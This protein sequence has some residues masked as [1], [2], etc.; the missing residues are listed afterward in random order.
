MQEIL[1]PQNPEQVRDAILWAA[2]S[3]T[4]LE[5][6]GAGSKRGLG[7]PVQAQYS[8]SLA[9]LKGILFYEPEELVLSAKA[10]TPLSV[11][12]QALAEKKQM[13]AFEPADYGLILNGEADQATLGGV[14]A[15]NLSGSRRFRAG[16]ARDHLLGFQAVNGRG[17][18]IKSGGRVMKNVSGYDL[19]KLMAGSYGTLSAMTEL[20]IKVLPA[21][22]VTS[23]L[24]I[25]RL[26]VQQA[27]KAMTAVASSACD[28]SGAAWLP[29]KVAASLS[30]E[31]KEEKG[32]SALLL[33]LEGFA[34]SVS[35]RLKALQSLLAA[36]G[37]GSVLEGKA[38]QEVWR[39]INNVSLLNTDQ[40]RSLW[41]IS[42]PPASA[43][44]IAA[45]LEA[46]P[47]QEMFID[48]AGGTIWLAMNEVGN[49]DAVKLR[50][51]ILPCGG[52]A[53]LISSNA[54]IRASVPVFHP[55]P[56]PLRAL[57]R[58]IKESFDPCRILNPGR[59][60]GGV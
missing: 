14:I 23:C 49:D 43:A 17:E 19:C 15:A 7:K 12:N 9:S 39:Q 56:Q 3:S 41:R 1:K 37:N 24:L 27:V 38:A 59:M 8:L 46:F 32:G 45:A 53:T 50:K 11:I 5:V 57:G 4:P 21:P 36:Y 34:P 22:E 13:L 30:L 47:G 48:Q 52:H 10:G 33:R 40:G 20:T 42:I 31:H 58:R 28:I 29:E 2:D 54:A 25:R 16:A 55:Q 35:M 44:E 26:N 6:M 51:A 18:F 60:Y